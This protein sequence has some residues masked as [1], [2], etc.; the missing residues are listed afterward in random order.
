MQQPDFSLPSKTPKL[1][2]V[3]IIGRLN[4]GGPARQACYLHQD[5][6]KRYE[7]VLVTGRLDK[8]EGDMSYLL[9]SQE[10][11]RWVGSMSRPVSIWSDLV[12]FVRIL[13]ILR[14]E[15]PEIVHTHT[16]K[17]GAL[18][19]VAASLMRVPV[20][21]HT[22]HGHVLQGYFSPSQTRLWVWI[23][24]LLGRF[25]T[26]VIAISPSLAD[27]LAHA[28]R[29]VSAQKISVIR[30]GFDLAPFGMNNQ[31]EQIR[32]EFAISESDFLVLWAGRMVPV[33]NLGLLG[34]IV[35]AAGS[36]PHIKFLV[37]GDGN[38]KARLK[39]STAGCGNISFAGWRTDMPALWAASDAALLTSTNEGT[40]TALVEAMAA[41]KPFVS[42]QVGGVIDLAVPPLEKSRAGYI[43]AANGFL[44]RANAAV[45]LDRLEQ[46]SR[47]PELA[48][49]MGRA[50]R[51]FV[52]K[53]HTQERLVRDV[54]KLYDE[55]TGCTGV[56]MKIGA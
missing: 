15:R 46:L 4:V 17:A 47:D 25:T 16:A 9:G 38:D 42:T 10:G 54:L 51:Q 18:G 37:V 33:K 28:Y 52:L 12:A 29:V 1:K 5:L 8:G 13:R 6:A 20:S 56:G 21:I 23:E 39:E 45:M 22:Y 53:Y 30:T 50:G 14:K 35:R 36:L 2:V 24:R 43:E 55:L 7:T 40:P 49:R 34:E 27:E 31:R 3:R 48:Q 41:G 11:V 44:T 32:R 26:R 19:R